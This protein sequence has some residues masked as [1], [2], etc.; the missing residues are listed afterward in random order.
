M[1]N[2]MQFMQ[3]MQSKNPQQAMM[4]VLNQQSRNN[5]ILK[6]VFDMVQN[7]DS[8]GI[9]EMAWNLAKEKGIN[10]DEAVQQIRKKFG[11]M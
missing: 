1:I 8:K 4:N 11:I 5:P 6:N 10:A 2:P 3:I 9:E 7:G